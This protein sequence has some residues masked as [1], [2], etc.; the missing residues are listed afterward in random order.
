MRVQYVVVLGVFF[1][2][3]GSQCSRVWAQEDEPYLA[4]HVPAPKDAIEVKVGVGYTQGL[5]MLAPNRDIDNVAGAGLGLG[6]EID[7]RFTPSW[8]LGVEGQYQEFANQQN[9]GARGLAANLGATYHF[10][11]GRA[12]DPW[13]RL[14]TGYRLVWETDPVG[15][16]GATVVRHGFDIV[17]AKVGYDVRLTPDLALGPVVG[18]DLN[19]FSW[20]DNNTMSSTQVGT[21]FYV[22]VQGRFDAGGKRV[23]QAVAAIEREPIDTIG[24][25]EAQPGSP[26]ATPPPLFDTSPGLSVSEEVMKTCDLK[27][28]VDT[29]PKFDF[30]RSD[31]QQSDL[32]ILKQLADCLTSGALKDARLHLIGRADPRGSIRYNNSLG[33]RR[34]QQVAAYLDQLGIGSDRITQSS[35]GKL[36][37]QG[38]DEDSWAVDRRVDIL[39]G[40]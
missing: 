5:G 34:A 37:A 1:G 39:L 6:A 22:G 9:T 40:E 14:G 16:P 12:S 17:S 36:D 4:R 26:I 30:D 32:A 11:P 8:S 35:R 24:V 2:I 23:P 27:L 10:I 18:A 20:Q 3:G 21:F 28:D 25:T 38:T 29:A 31:L 13:V 19:V 7:Y 15:S 33:A